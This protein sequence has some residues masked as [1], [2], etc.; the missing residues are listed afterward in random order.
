M[1]FDLIVA[2]IGFI[3]YDQLVEAWYDKKNFHF[4]RKKDYK[5]SR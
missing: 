1:V 4:L 5:E 2:M 3:W